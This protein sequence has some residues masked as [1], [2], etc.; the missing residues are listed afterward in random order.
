ME[1]KIKTGV[2][3]EPLGD[4][5]GTKLPDVQHSILAAYIAMTERFEKKS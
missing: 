3:W 1:E 4:I 5:M 2:V